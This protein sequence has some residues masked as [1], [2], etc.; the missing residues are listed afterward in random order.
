MSDY[1]TNNDDVY[2]SINNDINNDI[3]ASQ[4]NDYYTSSGQSNDYYTSTGQPGDYYASSNKADNYYAST[5]KITEDDL[6][7]KNFVIQ[8]NKPRLI[9]HV[10]ALMIPIGMYMMFYNFIKYGGDFGTYIAWLLFIMF[11]GFAIFFVINVGKKIEIIDK[12]IIITRLFY[13]KEVIS[14]KDITK[15][16]VITG[17]TSH[18]RYHTDH[19]NKVVIYYTSDGKNKKVDMTDNLYTGYNELVRY[20]DYFVKCDF[21]DGRSWFS[22]F[23]DNN[24]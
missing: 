24:Y 14:L 8:M 7:N 20:M 6:V 10:I 1:Y 4:S 3:N 16:E 2:N 17:L 13:R 9:L 23:L 15:C 21:I 12:T 5:D 22:R 19:Y 11:M 18:G